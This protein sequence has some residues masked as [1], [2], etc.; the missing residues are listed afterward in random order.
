MNRESRNSFARLC[1]IILIKE[2]D[3]LIVTVKG[4]RTF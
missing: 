4:L 3:Y 1:L 2:K